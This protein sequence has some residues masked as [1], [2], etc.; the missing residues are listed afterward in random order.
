MNL[1]SW[2]TCKILRLW[3]KELDYLPH[4]EGIHSDPPP[5]LPHPSFILCSELSSRRVTLPVWPC[6][7][8]TAQ[9]VL[10][11]RCLSLSQYQWQVETGK[12]AILNRRYLDHKD[13]QYCCA[14]SYVWCRFDVEIPCVILLAPSTPNVVVLNL[15]TFGSVNLSNVW[16]SVVLEES[17]HRLLRCGHHHDHGTVCGHMDSRCWTSEIKKTTWTMC[18]IW[19]KQK[20]QQ[21]SSSPGKFIAVIWKIVAPVYASSWYR[22]S[23]QPTLPPVFFFWGGG[24]GGGGWLVF[25]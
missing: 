1:V 20:G 7:R 5:L 25:F 8:F 3:W 24:E 15:L 19:C 10:S 16:I 11:E 22:V 18:E 9:F 12:G 2:V 13:L 14:E 17:R 6:G 4:E 23:P 21:I